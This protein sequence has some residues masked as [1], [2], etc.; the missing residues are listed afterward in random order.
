MK[1]LEHVLD[2]VTLLV[3]PPPT[4]C[5]ADRAAGELV[6]D[7]SRRAVHLVEA[8]LVDVEQAQRITGDGAA[9]L[10]R[11]ALG[12]AAHAPG[13]F[14]MRGVPRPTRDPGRPCPRAARPDGGRTT[15][16]FCR[17]ARS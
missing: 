15:Q 10:F 1:R 3:P 9:M 12:E 6:D 5:R 13:G 14:A 2:R 11:R 16:I 7:V 17:S 4:A 8:G